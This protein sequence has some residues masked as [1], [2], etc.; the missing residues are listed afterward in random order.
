MVI[1]F[2]K[3]KTAY[4]MRIS[5]WS[6]DVCSSDLQ[7][8]DEER[9]DGHHGNRR[10]HAQEDVS[11]HRRILAPARPRPGAAVPASCGHET[12]RFQ[13]NCTGERILPVTV[14]RY[15]TGP[16]YFQTLPYAP[17]APSPHFTSLAT[18]PFSSGTFLSGTA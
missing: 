5:D 8:K 11:Q 2:F 4:E 17:I 18:A 15:A 14:L 3:Q 1:F 13:K 9:N 10:R 12:D 6:S 16:T 7:Q